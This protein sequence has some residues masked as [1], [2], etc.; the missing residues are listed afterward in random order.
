MKGLLHRSLNFACYF[1]KLNNFIIFNQV[2][3]IEYHREFTNL[4]GS[5]LF[6]GSSYIQYNVKA[7]SEKCANSAVYQINNFLSVCL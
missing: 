4:K 3:S 5:N 7:E 1:L 6:M 2:Y